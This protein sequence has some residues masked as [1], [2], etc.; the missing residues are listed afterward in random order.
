MPEV[1]GCQILD[2]DRFLRQ[3]SPNTYLLFSWDTVF[4]EA[5][6]VINHSLFS[7]ENKLF[8]PNITRFF[9]SHFAALKTAFICILAAIFPRL[10][11]AWKLF[12]SLPEIRSIELRKIESSSKVSTL[13]CQMNVLMKLRLWNSFKIC[14]IKC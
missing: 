3:K 12:K 6:S 8:W 10:R 9:S 13:A 4:P 14:T 5:S 7:A 2:R 1:P 11:K